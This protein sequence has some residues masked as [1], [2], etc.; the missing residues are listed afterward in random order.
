M[1]ECIYA[2]I[3]DENIMC[4]FYAFL[5]YI[6]A[7]EISTKNIGLKVSELQ[8]KKHCTSLDRLYA[9]KWLNMMKRKHLPLLH[10]LP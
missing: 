6:I 10:Q 4:D 2:S 8:T 1:G 9:V 3:Y 7:L 5:V